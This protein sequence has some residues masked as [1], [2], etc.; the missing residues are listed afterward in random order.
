M[1]MYQAKVFFWI[2]IA[3]LA[4]VSTG[5]ATSG[6]TCIADDSLKQMRRAYDAGVMF[7]AGGESYSWGVAILRDKSV[8]FRATGDR[9]LNAPSSRLVQHLNSGSMTYTAETESGSIVVTIT[10]QECK[11]DA[12]GERSKFSAEV[13]VRKGIEE[14]FT[15]YNGCG[16]FV[17]DYGLEG[18]WVLH[19][20]EN[21]EIDRNTYPVNLPYLEFVPDSALVRGIGG[22]NRIYSNYSQ[23]GNRFSFG[24]LVSTEMGCPEAMREN[25]IISRL[26]NANT[27]SL[28]NGELELS[29]E[30]GV[31][32]VYLREGLQTGRDTSGSTGKRNILNDIWALERIGGRELSREEFPPPI[33]EMHLR[34]AVYFISS[35]CSGYRGSFACTDETIAF[36]KAEETERKCDAGIETNLLSALYSAKKWTAENLRLYVTDGNKV[37]LVFR[38]ID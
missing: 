38:K 36:G 22:C 21:S 16:R 5:Y 35:E 37:L 15:T 26:K 7:A 24:E 13:K 28:I 20:I 29:N 2:W 3:V 30:S 27:Y 8:K 10:P 33:L 12:T 11:D 32:L 23:E 25:E 1:T 31:K 14:K 19:K 17:P 9:S 18:K 4:S 6:T 34:D